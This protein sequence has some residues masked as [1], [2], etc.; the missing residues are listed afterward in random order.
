MR[1]LLATLALLVPATAAAVD[2]PCHTPAF[3]DQLTAPLGPAVVI[4]ATP[5]D[6]DSRNPYGVPNELETENFVIRW[7]NSWSENTSGIDNLA[8]AL[9]DAWDTEIVDMS[10]P[11]PWS[12]DQLLINVYIGDTGGGTPGSFGAGGYFNQDES[13]YPMLV[14]APQSLDDLPWTRVVAIHEFYHAV[15]WGLGTYTYS[16]GEPGAWYWEATASWVPSEVD[17]DSPANISFLWGFA[18]AAHLPLDAF[19]YPDS[20]QL[21]EYHQYG[22]A[23][24]PTYVSEHVADWQ[25]IRNSWVAPAGGTSDPIEALRGELADLGEDFDAVF[26][27]FVAHNVFWDYA[28]GN[29]FEQFV[30]GGQQ[31]YPGTD[32][33]T[34][35][36]TDEGTGAPD[37]PPM[38]YGSNTVRFDL[39]D[40]TWRIDLA[41]DDVGSAG[42]PASWGVTLVTD[43][44]ADIS[45]TPIEVVD[46]AASFELHSDGDEAGLAVASWT[47]PR[48]GGER[49]DWSWDVTF[50]EPPGDD[51]DDDTAPFGDDDDDVGG[52]SGNGCGCSAT[53]DAAPAAWLLLLLPFSRRRRPR[54]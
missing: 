9:E 41:F 17:P 24:F 14:I 22:A 5:R 16:E 45:Y 36:I 47:G 3:F 20:G 18:L 26:T 13:G 6:K 27:D 52:F 1:L 30:S 37:E 44:G 35:W 38:R 4:D 2:H 51:D 31:A 46:G 29:V 11:A 49:F 42:N 54:P 33:V 34:A 48:S 23:I 10:H 21:Q 43:D 50:V 32:P 15:Q 28:H 39:D 25:P 53:S 19:D 7:G 40:G 12:A 8:A